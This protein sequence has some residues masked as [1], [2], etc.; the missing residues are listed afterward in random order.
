MSVTAHGE[1]LLVP[2]DPSDVVDYAF[3]FDGDGFA[4]SEAITGTPTVV[5]DPI[6]GDPSPLVVGAISL[7]GSPVRTVN[8]FFSAGTAG[9]V[10]AVRITFVT[11][12]SR[13]FQRTFRLPVVDL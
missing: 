6:A 7:S 4:P 11:N 12:Q 3:N 10:Y 13:T 1:L 8:V 5:V 9:N 2:K